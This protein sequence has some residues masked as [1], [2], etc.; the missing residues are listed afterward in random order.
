MTR[1][2]NDKG[3]YFGAW[4]LVRAGDD[5]EIGR[6]AALVAKDRRFKPASTAQDLRKL[7]G[8]DQAGGDLYDVVESAEMDWLAL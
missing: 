1:E 8:E 5:T 4:L 6:L 7:L 3:E 2:R